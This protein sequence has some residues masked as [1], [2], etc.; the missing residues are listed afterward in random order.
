MVDGEKRTQLSCA[1]DEA[2]L[3]PYENVRFDTAQLRPPVARMCERRSLLRAGHTPLG[4]SRAV[5][6]QMQASSKRN[7]TVPTHSSALC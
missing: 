7:T 2:E 1:R 5:C 3:C 6:R 4:Q